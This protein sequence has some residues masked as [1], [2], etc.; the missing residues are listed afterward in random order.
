M[1]N[2]TTAKASTTAIARVDGISAWWSTWQRHI[3]RWLLSDYVPWITAESV[4]LVALLSHSI[5][6]HVQI[7][8]DCAACAQMGQMLF[9]GQMP[10]VDFY[11][12]N[13]PAIFYINLL[14][15]AMSHVLHQPL[16]L[17]FSLCVGMLV[18]L[19]WAQLR[20]AIRRTPLRITTAEN[21]LI[22]LS[23]L[24]INALIYIRGDFGQREHL[25]ALAYLPALAA[26]A[27]CQEGGRMPLG[28]AIWLGIQA[29]IGACIKPHFVL[30]AVAV[31]ACFLAHGRKWKS[32][33]SPDAMAFAAVIILYLLHWLVLP[34][35]MRDGYFHR[36]LPFAMHGYT[37]YERTLGDLIANTPGTLFLVT[38]V[39]GWFMLY[40]SRLRRPMLLGFNVAAIAG[41][42]ICFMQ[43]KAW[44]YHYIP[45]E[46][47]ATL[48][49]A[50]LVAQLARVLATDK[51]C[52]RLRMPALLWLFFAAVGA[53]GVAVRAVAQ[54]GIGF[55]RL[56]L[57]AGSI[58]ET[59]ARHTS[60]GDHA[61]VLSTSCE[62]VEPLFVQLGLRLGQRCGG[63]WFVIP[64]NQTDDY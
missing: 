43:R 56:S 47:A 3:Y 14:P 29:G 45:F 4:I 24:A 39:G 28:T 36:C 5:L 41:L 37:A 44:T 58:E 54:D 23:W 50:V 17:S 27:V 46:M 31:E 13:P 35:A 16:T 55:E 34:A 32:L 8:H 62:P 59:I 51:A 42:A 1:Q 21:S 57:E 15:A 33:I 10:Y 60:P 11:D 26:R 18:A 61:I 30:I 19:S 52:R 64:G 7:N 38:A 40:I 53:A 49:T 22:T 12:I 9:E 25:F 2:L 63:L 6:H 20:V 48:A